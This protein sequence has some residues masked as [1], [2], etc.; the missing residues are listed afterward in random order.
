M[1][2]GGNVRKSTSERKTYP[3]VW[4]MDCMR[5][6]GRG[7]KV[8]SIQ[9]NHSWCFPLQCSSHIKNSYSKK[10]PYS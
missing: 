5:G 8:I 1:K 3:G 2:E 7:A 9:D 4:T 10:Y 6:W